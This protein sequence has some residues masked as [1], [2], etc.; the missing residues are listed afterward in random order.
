MDNEVFCHESLHLLEIQKWHC[1][2]SLLI[3]DVHLLLPV[4]HSV[5]RRCCNLT[6]VLLIPFKV[7]IT[8]VSN[9]TSFYLKDDLWP[10]EYPK[11]SWSFGEKHSHNIILGWYFLR[12][13][14]NSMLCL[15]N[16][17]LKPWVS[18]CDLTLCCCIFARS[19]VQTEGAARVSLLGI[20][21][22]E[23]KK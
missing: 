10:Q 4:L 21:N 13:I 11:L 14:S 7:I 5:R 20:V 17:S 8:A 15:S 22:I 16:P 6:L 1:T 18:G 12:A 2:G 3:K 23:E 19:V 9:V